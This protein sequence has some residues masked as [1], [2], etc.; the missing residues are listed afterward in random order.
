M[1]ISKNVEWVRQN[2]QTVTA[3]LQ[4]VNIVAATK[5]ANCDQMI[6]LYESGITMMGENRVDALLQKRGQLS[7]PIE[8]HF[9]GTLQSRKVK[10]MINE[11]ACLHSLDRLSLAKEIQKYRKEPLPCFVQVNVSKEESKHGLSQEEVIPFL[12]SLQDYSMIKVIGLMT[13]APNTADEAVIRECFKSLK[14]LQNSISQLNLKGVT[15]L[16]LSM[17]MSNDYLIAIEEGATY[18]R[19]GSIL[20][21]D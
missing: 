2:I 11:I 8:W 4:T 14:Q 6:A 3:N 10:E 12:K 1:T 19:L 5:Y 18:I 7:L 17:G 15:C 16:N 20:F 21:Q 9:I 13:M